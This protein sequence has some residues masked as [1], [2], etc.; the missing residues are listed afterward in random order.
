MATSRPHSSPDMDLRSL[1]RDLLLSERVEETGKVLIRAPHYSMIEVTVGGTLESSAVKLEEA[2]LEL[3]E[4]PAEEYAAICGRI[5]DECRQHSSLRHPNVVQF[6]GLFFPATSTLPLVIT[7]HMPMSLNDALQRFQDLPDMIGRSILLDAARGLQYIH[8]LTPSQPHGN[9]SANSV[10]ITANFRAKINYLGI[11]NAVSEMIEDP[12]ALELKEQ[13]GVGAQSFK[14]DIYNFGELMVYVI[15]RR[16]P[17]RTLTSLSSSLLHQIENVDT[18]S[19]FRRLIMQCL[20]KDLLSRPTASE[21]VEELQVITM[22]DR[23]TL[24][25]PGRVLNLLLQ[26]PSSPLNGSPMNNSV[27]GKLK[28]LQIENSRLTAQLKVTQS[29]LR[30]LRLQTSLLQDEEDEEEEE[31]VVEEKVISPLHKSAKKVECKD[32]AVQ[33]EILHT[34]KRRVSS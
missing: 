27:D 10:M 15:T 13:D 26:K 33:V 21:I 32:Q 19:P 8:S 9:I 12:E 4:S 16:R 23:P 18:R 29:E 11:C 34:H 25:D 28:R 1:L 20:Q 30:H 6:L 31:E 3:D 14:S 24:Q 22:T 2:A 17:R 5:A 7:E